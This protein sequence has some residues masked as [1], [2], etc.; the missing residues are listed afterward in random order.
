MQVTRERILAYLADHPPSSAEEIGRYLE[1]TPA[2]IR[3]HLDILERE[4]LIQIAGKRP[5]GG[6]GRLILLYRLTSFSLGENL[7][8]LLEAL[9]E[10][11]PAAA[12][13]DQTLEAI[14][15][16]LLQGKAAE[17][18]NRVQ[19]FNQGVEFL[20]TMHYH[21]SWEARPQGPRVE[22]RHCP[23]RDL[24]RRHPLLCQLDQQLLNDVFGAEFKAVQLRTKEERPF[25]PCIFQTE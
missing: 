3:Y 24:P 9:L 21:A 2:N 19:R 17:R 4:G 12:S 10:T 5:T 14:S 15:D 6:A 1:M 23:Y 7:V 25:S 20:N 18:R 16:N 11:L 8:P 13:L 22:L